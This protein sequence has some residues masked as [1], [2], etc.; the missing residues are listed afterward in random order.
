[1][2]ADTPIF[3]AAGTL[4]VYGTLLIDFS[5]SRYQQMF[6]DGRG[7]TYMNTNSSATQIDSNIDHAVFN[8]SG[9]AVVMPDDLTCLSMI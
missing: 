8:L 9:P 6:V 1:M 4:L 2:C 7:N 5:I 3:F